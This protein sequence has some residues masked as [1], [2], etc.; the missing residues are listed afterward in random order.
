[1]YSLGVNQIVLRYGNYQVFGWRTLVDPNGASQDWINA[2]NRRLTM[3]MTAKALAILETY[4]LDEIDGQGRM[5]TRLKG[6]LVGMCA[7]YYTMGSLYGLTPEDAFSVDTGPQV[8]TL[9]TIANREV[10]AAIAA[11][12][13]PDA[14]LVVLEISKIPVSQS[15]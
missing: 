5:F 13:S 15:L 6:Q 10:H 2:G 1:M 4:I 7:E 8:N 9:A 14:E 12:M 11:R 3:A